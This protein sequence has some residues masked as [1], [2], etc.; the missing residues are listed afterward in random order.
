LLPDVLTA[1][2]SVLTISTPLSIKAL[3]LAAI[4]AVIPELVEDAL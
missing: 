3:S 4:S 1:Q 2:A